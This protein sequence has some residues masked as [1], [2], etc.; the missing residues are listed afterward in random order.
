MNKRQRKK[1]LKRLLPFFFDGLQ[2]AAALAAISYYM[3][4]VAGYS[5]PVEEKRRIIESLRERAE[6]L[7]GG[8]RLGS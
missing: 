2:R 4:A 7:A 1:A 5:A 8:G 6:A 3:S